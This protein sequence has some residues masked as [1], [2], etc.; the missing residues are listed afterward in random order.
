MDPSCAYAK[1]VISADT[2]AQLLSKPNR[3]LARRRDLLKVELYYL[4]F[5]LFQSQFVDHKRQVRTELVSID[6]VQGDVVYLKKFD[7][8]P[9]PP[10]SL[11]SVPPTLSWDQ[12]QSAGWEGLRRNLFYH[13]WRVQK[14]Q[15]L[16]S[17]IPERQFYYPFWLGYFKRRNAL[18]LDAVDAVSGKRQGVRIKTI[19]I[20]A[21]LTL[22]K[23]SK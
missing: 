20:Q 5:Y 9:N 7:W 12:A 16:L 1:P 3:P 15:R 10:L 21:L 19:F 23:R 11:D 22:Y 14:N 13:G 4:P 17:L 18:D 2:A 6:A 8:E